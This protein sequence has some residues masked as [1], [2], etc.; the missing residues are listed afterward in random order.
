MPDLRTCR[1]SGGGWADVAEFGHELAG[2]FED[3]TLRIGVEFSDGGD[4]A[5]H[6]VRV[7]EH[8][9]CAT[10]LFEVFADRTHRA[11]Q[12]VLLDRPAMR[13]EP[14]DDR[15]DDSPHERSRER[16]FEPR[17]VRRVLESQVAAPGE[18]R[19][20]DLSGIEAMVVGEIVE[21]LEHLVGLVM[22][23]ELE[24]DDP[25][26]LGGIHGEQC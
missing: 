11:T 19:D 15:P 8:E 26:W 22:V 23:A 12:V 2:E 4:D 16:S 3:L 18:S 20:P 24:R 17:V 5:L 13:H 9:H 25:V 7:G 10:A 21:V 14:A 1:C 6:T